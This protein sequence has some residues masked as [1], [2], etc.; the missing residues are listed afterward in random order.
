MATQSSLTN[1]LDSAPEWKSRF[2]YARLM[3]ERDSWCVPDR[4]E[5]RFPK[6]ISESMVGLEAH[7]RASCYSGGVGV[8]FVK[9]EEE[10]GEEEMPSEEGTSISRGIDEIA[11]KV[12]P[13]VVAE[14]LAE[15]DQAKMVGPTSAGLHSSSEGPSGLLFQGGPAP[16]VSMGEPKPFVLEGSELE[17]IKEDV[18][19]LLKQVALLRSREAKL[20]SKRDAAQTE[21]TQLGLREELEAS[22]AQVARLQASSQ[23][24]DVR[25][26]VIA[27]Y[28]RNNIYRHREE[29]ERSHYS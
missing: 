27:K 1:L 15:P 23:E 8:F 5:E 18:S 29:Y 3:S 16:S 26:L 14:A 6:P 13:I 28:L 25:S 4:W 11:P 9:S 24:G 19:L 7:Q 22:H 17:T 10:T 2:F 20:L 12:A 21:A